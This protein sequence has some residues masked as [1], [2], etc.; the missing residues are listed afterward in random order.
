MMGLGLGAVAMPVVAQRLIA[1]FGWRKAF[2]IVGCAMLTIP[3]P[4]VGF[5]SQRRA[6]ANG[7]AT[8]RG[9]DEHRASTNWQPAG[10]SSRGVTR[11][12]AARSDC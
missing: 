2:A 5:F 4:I 9:I 6:R 10:W 3:V 8:R 12:R 1:S 11:G 7:T